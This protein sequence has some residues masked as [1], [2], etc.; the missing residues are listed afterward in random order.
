MDSHDFWSTGE[1]RSTVS[2]MNFSLCRL[3]FVL[4]TRSVSDVFQCFLMGYSGRYLESFFAVFEVVHACS[5][6]QL[7][8]LWPCGLWP[9]RL[10]CSWDFPARILEWVALFYSRGPSWPRIEPASPALQAD[11]LPLSHWGSP[12]HSGTACQ[13]LWS[14]NSFSTSYL[15]APFLSHSVR[16]GNASKKS[17]SL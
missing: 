6:A 14:P 7:D 17:R 5:V 3:S 10:L 11:S 4:V 9:A 16:S 8:F 1:L 13:W 12:L 15:A 2:S